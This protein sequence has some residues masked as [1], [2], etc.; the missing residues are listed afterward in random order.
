MLVNCESCG[1]QMF[2]FAGQ[3]KSC[4]DCYQWNKVSKIVRREI[5]ELVPDYFTTKGVMDKE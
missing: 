1:K 2:W 3:H 5:E 4:D